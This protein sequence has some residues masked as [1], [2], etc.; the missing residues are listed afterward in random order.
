MHSQS[1]ICRRSLQERISTGVYG[2]PACCLQQAIVTSVTSREAGDTEP[3]SGS[4]VW[5]DNQEPIG[6]V[7]ELE[8]VGV[9]QVVTVHLVRERTVADDDEAVEIGAVV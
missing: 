7:P 8:P 4:I 3:R 9:A 5:H 1:V 2:T 6:L